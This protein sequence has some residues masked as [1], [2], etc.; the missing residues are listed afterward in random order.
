MTKFNRGEARL[1]MASKVNPGRT[2]KHQSGTSV[3]R[4]F[5]V[6]LLLMLGTG[7]V[8]LTSTGKLDAVS[9]ALVFIA[10]A[11]RLWG[12]ATGR[13]LQLSS[14]TVNRLALLYIPFFILDYLVL[15]AGT[16][17]LVSMLNATL[18]LV[19][20][21]TV[22]KVFSAVTR[23]DYAYLAALSLLMILAT[24]VLTINTTFM[25]FLILY[26]FFAISTLISYE[27][28]R[29]IET[30]R[31]SVTNRLL[32]PAADRT[33]IENALV[34]TAAGLG[35]GIVATAAVFFFVIPRYRSG[36]LTGLG[37]G[38]EN[39]TG[40]SGTV[41]LGDLSRL[42]RSSTVIFRVIPQGNPRQYI[43]IKW[44]GVALDSFDGK[45]WYNDNTRQTAVQPVSYN[46]FIIPF[47]PGAKERPEKTLSYTVLLSPISSDVL[48]AAPFARQLSGRIH[49]LLLDETGSIHDT[50]YGLSSLKYE[51]VSNVGLPPPSLLRSAPESYSSAIRLLY[52]RLPLRLDPRIREL[53]EKV[54]SSATNNYDRAVE[55]RNYLRDHF[56][57][58]LAA[59]NIDPSDPIGSFLF[60][61]RKGYCEYF[62]SAMAIMLRTLGIPARLVNGFQTGSYNSFGKDFVVRARDAHSWV[63]VYF[64]HYGW[65]PFD[66]TPPD[67]NPVIPSQLDNYVDALTLFWSEWVIN[68]DFSHQVRLATQVEVQSHNVQEDVS[69]RFD[70]LRTE[71]AG[72]AKKIESLLVAHK[73]LL[74]VV[75]LAMTAAFLLGG[76]NWDFQ[77]LR[78]LWAS[79]VLRSERP[80]SLQEATYSYHHFL[81]ILQTK[82]FRKLPCETPEEFVQKIEPSLLR[83]KAGDFTRLYNAARY[84]GE[85]PSLPIVAGMLQEISA[86]DARGHSRQ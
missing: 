72:M 23:R 47:P 3:D 2:A 7:F 85:R 60:T 75:M 30:S 43:G 36:Y 67:P 80:L 29:S 40:F 48:F 71:L 55:I 53:A 12:Y 86:L 38:T 46:R 57:Y 61:T 33:R 83:G 26:L 4:F 65:I 19:L 49:L 59:Q 44:R 5:A 81:N 13:N 50:R 41:K 58:T 62:A 21:A 11:V 24:A 52:L 31:R 8:T 64:P 66:P 32:V 84:G 37:T 82:G 45:H 69:H 10:I 42:M 1:Q 51:V 22:T 14:Q 79:M 35:L 54:S 28:K 17:S 74:L 20:F 25:I 16:T 63:E 56:G 78:F 70:H 39:I 18:H 27:I 73:F 76:K 15:S 6:S 9:V 77:E 34:K 68:Y